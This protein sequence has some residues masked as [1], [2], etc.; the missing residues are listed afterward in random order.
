MELPA[1]NIVNLSLSFA[2][3]MFNV[4][5]YA[6]NVTDDDTPSAI[7]Y[8]TDWNQAINGSID[9]LYIVPRRPREIGLRV[10]VNFGQQR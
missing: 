4:R 3:Q 9:N 2:N 7:G 5:L 10:Q 6:N 8:G 1:T